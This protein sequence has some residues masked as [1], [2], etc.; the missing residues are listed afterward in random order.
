MPLVAKIAVAVAPYSI[1][2][3]YDYLVPEELE[4]SL[5]PG[6][7]AAVPFGKGN[8]ASDGI[9][10]SVSWEK[11][12]S[13]RESRAVEKNSSTGGAGNYR[14]FRKCRRDSGLQRGK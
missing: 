6:M 7:R 14:F 4:G 12:V 5:R 13:E 10:L 11:T 2:R 8:K 9:V 1:D 3:P